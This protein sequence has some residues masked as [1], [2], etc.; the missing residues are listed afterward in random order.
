MDGSFGLHGTV[1]KIL[2]YG[3]FGE[4]H[5][6]EMQ[7]KRLVISLS[8]RSAILATFSWEFG[9]TSWKRSM[10][11]ISMTKSHKTLTGTKRALCWSFG[12]PRV[13]WFSPQLGCFSS[14]YS[15]S[16]RF[17]NSFKI[18]CELPLQILL[19]PDRLQMWRQCRQF[20]YPSRP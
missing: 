16:K 18:N 13:S 5:E 11:R 14:S 9:A 1:M 4:F 19:F 7:P 17:A 15:C 12:W 2:H 8:I 20:G 6:Y 10:R 3:H